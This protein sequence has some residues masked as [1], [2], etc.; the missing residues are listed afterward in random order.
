M[1]LSNEGLQLILDWEVGG[2]RAYYDKQL[3]HPI[4]PDPE[5]TDSGVT[6]GI[7]WDCGYNTERTLQ[8]EWGE[9]LGEDVIAAFKPVLRLRGMQAKAALPSVQHITIAWEDALKQFTTYTVPRY[10][11][12]TCTA[13]PGI[14]QAPQGVQEALLSLVFNRGSGMDGDRRLE[15]R[16]IRALVAAGAWGDIAA[17]IRDIKRLWPNTRGLV[18]RREAEQLS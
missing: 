11:Q 8:T 5:H 14:E 13:F 3:Q 6:I 18:R 17:K 10:W 7:G 2:G 9:C 15:M 1:N 16:E 12:M 4:V